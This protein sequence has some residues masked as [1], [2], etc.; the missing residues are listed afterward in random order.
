MGFVDRVKRLWRGK[1]TLP[2]RVENGADGA[3]VTEV[4][5]VRP[6]DVVDAYYA[7]RA[8]AP[9]WDS[10]KA[11][12][13]GM[14]IN[15]WVNICVSK[16]AESVGSI[17][18]YVERRKGA[19]WARA[20]DSPLHVLL[21]EPNEAWDWRAL[22][23]TVTMQLWLAGNALVTKVRVGEVPAELW[24]LGPHNTDVIAGEPGQP[25]I[26]AYEYTNDSGQKT[27]VASEDAI[28]FR[29]Q[30]PTNKYWGLSPVRSGGYAID[31]DVQASSWQK[32]SLDNMMV[33]PGVFLYERTI[34]SDQ[35][36]AAKERLKE[37][38]T[39]AQNARLPLILGNNAKWQ[40][41][42]LTPQE[43]DFIAS[44]KLTREEICALFRVPPP[45]VGILDNSTYNNISTAERIYWET[46][47]VPFVQKLR[48]GF[49]RALAPEFGAEFRFAVDLS[50]VLPLLSRL[51]ER[52]E[53]AKSFWFMGVPY[54]TIEQRLQLGTG[55]IPGG[56]QGW[57]P[58]TVQPADDAG[59]GDEL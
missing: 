37:E 12:T 55:P 26:I 48:D 22:V 42:T 56:D 32:N 5:S 49:N 45:I 15:S 28:H 21:E 58:S 50:G 20:D 16:N 13:D 30:H 34:T 10:K 47:A 2:A 29:F 19:D 36:K 3:V 40:Q 44:R 51:T 35:L 41:M 46:N 9:D 23:E 11:V 4:K 1:T 8:K 18:W 38:Y 14:E 33:P 57:V 43:L 31:A 54:N 52:L 53:V 7:G 24:T 27:R 6:Q 25:F 39:G 59:L 17:P